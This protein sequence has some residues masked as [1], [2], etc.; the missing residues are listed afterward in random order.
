MKLV[1][2]K[3]LDH[4]SFDANKRLAMQPVHDVTPNTLTI[5]GDSKQVV[6]DD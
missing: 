6:T 3:W 4:C 5:E 1:Y 2:I